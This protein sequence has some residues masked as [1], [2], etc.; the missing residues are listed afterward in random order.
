MANSKTS[1]TKQAR[2]LYQAV[3]HLKTPSECAKFFRD[4]LTDDEIKEFSSRWQ[5]VRCIDKGLTYREISSITGLSTATITRVG[6]WFR[7]D[8][9]AGG[10]RMILKR[11][12]AN[13]ANK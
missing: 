1:R 11:V 9:G 8:E 5:V 7:K 12:K 2:E 10:Y 4:L 6:K 3:V 13:V